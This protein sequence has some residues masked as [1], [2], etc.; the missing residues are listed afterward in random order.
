[1]LR[2]NKLLS[3]LLEGWYQSSKSQNF[4]AGVLLWSSPINRKRK[5]GS[6]YQVHQKSIDFLCIFTLLYFYVHFNLFWW[7]WLSKV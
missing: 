2:Q 6:F 1:M 3:W 5:G 4:T 7:Q